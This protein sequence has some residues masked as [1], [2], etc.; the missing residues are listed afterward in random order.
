[1]Q[2]VGSSWF[3][4][5]LL[6][7]LSKSK[8]SKCR[9]HSPY[10][11]ANNHLFLLVILLKRALITIMIPRKGTVL[12]F[13]FL[14]FFF[15][16]FGERFNRLFFENFELVCINLRNYVVKNEDSDRYNNNIF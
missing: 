5:S 9:P 12:T 7:I 15:A 3:W 13:I 4:H 11:F 14:F 10:N 8:R 6:G 2:W 16:L 1:M